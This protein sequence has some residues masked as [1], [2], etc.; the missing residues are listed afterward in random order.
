[1]AKL[2]YYALCSRGIPAVKRHL[3]CIPKEDL[4]IVLNSTNLEFL[5]EAEA[6]CTEQGIEHYTT[7]CDETAPT[8]K[9]TVFDLFLHSEH[10]YMVLVD[11]DD[12][13]TPH[14]LVTY[15]KIANLESPPDAVALE[16][17]YGIVPNE[18]YHPELALTSTAGDGSAKTNAA[19][20]HNQDHIHGW[21]IRVFL[22]PKEW[23]DKALAGTSVQ[24]W[25]E[26]TQACSDAHQELYSFEHKYVNGWETHLRITF[27]SRKAAEYRF[28][29]SLVVGEDTMQ[30]FQL[31]NAWKNGDIDIVHLHET[32]PTYVYDQRIG[33]VVYHANEDDDGRGWLNW[34]TNLN[35]AFRAY[36]DAGK[37][38]TDI[39]EHIELEF[40]EGYRPD[41]LGLVNFPCRTIKY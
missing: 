22:H 33:G 40:D 17:Q 2:K 41:T 12:F 36:E 10:E 8:G 26:F 20:I 15:D 34:M 16:Y 11:G 25:D 37:M 35:I 13:I 32:Y 28:D 23:W 30:Y 24:V 19:D 7:E 31:K 6:W 3:R 38:H 5:A 29:T 14:G 18:G 21:G 39:P 4:V 27:Y 1:M 9:N